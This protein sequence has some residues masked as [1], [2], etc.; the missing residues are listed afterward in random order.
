[1]NAEVTLDLNEGLE[2]EDILG[3]EEMAEE[4]SGAWPKG[5]YAAEVIEGF[6][7]KKGKVIQTADDISKKG[8]SRNLTLCL[9]VKNG[10]DERTLIAST[11][12][13]T[14]DF[15]P[16]RIAFVKEARKEN[17]GVRGAWQD[18]D[19][20][21]SSLAL[22]S[23]GG[24]TK[25]MGFAPKLTPA[26]SLVAGIYVGQLVDVYLGTDEKGFNEARNFAPFGTKTGATK[27]N[28]HAKA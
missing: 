15:G 9:K 11:N 24:L 16:E 14:S 20:Q 7:T 4:P 3:L 1:M 23:I 21:R 2:A 28:G 25:A 13:R 18:R 19:A 10:K 17:A 5:W 12:Y 6:Q 22:A 26:G 8:D 27:P